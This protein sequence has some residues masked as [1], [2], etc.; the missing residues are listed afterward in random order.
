MQPSTG[1]IVLLAT[2]LCV[3][4]DPAQA[5]NDFLNSGPGNDALYGGAGDDVLVGGGGSSVIIAGDGV[6][7]LR[8]WGTTCGRTC[9]SK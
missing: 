5:G 4:Y 6:S 2:G 1:L 8:R 7:G 9:I 3:S